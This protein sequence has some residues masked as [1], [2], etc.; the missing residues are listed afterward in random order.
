MYVCRFQDILNGTVFIQEIAKQMEE[1][2]Q[3]SLSPITPS[4]Y[5][6]KDVSNTCYFRMEP[7]VVVQKL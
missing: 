7:R 6:A 2:L 5:N 1:V 4:C 3:V